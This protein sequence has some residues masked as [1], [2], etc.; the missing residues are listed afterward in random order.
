MKNDKQATRAR[1]VLGEVLRAA[2]SDSTR[3]RD[4]FLEIRRPSSEREK[5]TERGRQVLV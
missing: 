2:L 5:D 3:P 4:R 1:R